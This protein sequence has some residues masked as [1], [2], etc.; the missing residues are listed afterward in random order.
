MDLIN[1]AFSYMP[2]IDENFM[3]KNI[4]YD[5]CIEQKNLD[6]HHQKNKNYSGKDEH[7]VSLT[8]DGFCYGKN[9]EIIKELSKIE[10]IKK[11]KI[12]FTEYPEIMDTR[13]FMS[14][15][16]AFLISDHQSHLK[17]LEIEGIFLETD[18]C[19]ILDEKYFPNL[20]VLILNRV[21]FFDSANINFSKLEYF[22]LETSSISVDYFKFVKGKNIEISKNCKN[23]KKITIKKFENLPFLMTSDFSV[24][25]N[26]REF[27]LDQSNFPPQ[28]I[29]FPRKMETLVLFNLP[30]AIWLPDEVTTFFYLNEDINVFNS[31]NRY[32]RFLNQRYVNVINLVLTCPRPLMA[33]EHFNKTEIKMLIIFD[34][35]KNEIWKTPMTYFDEKFRDL[36]VLNYKTENSKMN[37]MSTL[38]NSFKKLPPSL[39]KLYIPGHTL[40]NSVNI[41]HNLGVLDFSV[42]KNL[43]KNFFTNMPYLFNLSMRGKSPYLTLSFD[44]HSNNF[45]ELLEITGFKGV[46]LKG[47]NENVKIV[48]SSDI[49]RTD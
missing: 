20:K 5:F 17:S 28:Q 24:F 34:K 16:F 15:L 37:N 23:V 1:D 43:D 4:E 13:R 42:T 49:R 35:E 29:I 30:A 26:L 2:I 36:K 21:M 39:T 46:E 41:P 11:I 14:N 18:S 10:K 22:Y 7:S 6:V 8:L 33:L 40:D 45:L 38:F 44:F 48:S 19:N 31:N 47:I 3:P 25:K 12:K 27:Y 32:Q 9:E